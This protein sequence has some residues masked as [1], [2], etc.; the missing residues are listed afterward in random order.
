MSIRARAAQTFSILSG[1]S[2]LS[3][4]GPGQRPAK[5]VRP[6]PVPPPDNQTSLKGDVW[7]VWVCEDRQGGVWV[8]AALNR[9]RPPAQTDIFKKPFC[10]DCLGG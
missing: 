7:I 2:F 4:F 8:R 9:S 6:D 5:T 3:L 1:S 10:L